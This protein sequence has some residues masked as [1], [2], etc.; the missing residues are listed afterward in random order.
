[1][2]S[3][4]EKSRTRR[5]LLAILAVATVIGHFLRDVLGFFAESAETD[6][7]KTTSDSVRGGVL[8][9]RTGKLDD[10][11]DAAGWYEKD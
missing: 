11:T 8:N 2:T 7:D 5:V 9:Y 10:G 4:A 3:T 1:M 6:S